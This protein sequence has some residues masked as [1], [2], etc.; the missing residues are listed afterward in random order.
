MRVIDKREYV[1][2]I[3]V[4]SIHV[5]NCFMHQNQ[6]FMKTDMVTSDGG[7]FRYCVNISSGEMSKFDMDEIVMP[8][9]AEC[10]I[11]DV[12]VGKIAKIEEVRNDE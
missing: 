5:G 8:V 10:I 11:D 2:P 7:R 6:V 9:A 12:L 4:E 3:N 1:L